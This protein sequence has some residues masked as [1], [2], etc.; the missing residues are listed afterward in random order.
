MSREIAIALDQ[1]FRPQPGGVATYAR[2]LVRGLE[3][4][5]DET[6][7]LVGVTPA[8]R[9]R[10]SIDVLGLSTVSAPLPVEVLTRAWAHVALGVPRSSD[11]VHATS[12]A[13]PF[14]GGRP[15]ARHSL[16][17]HDLLWRDE[18]T[19]STRRG[20]RFHESR[21]DLLR[22]REDVRVITT[23]PGL[24]SRLLADGFSADRLFVSRF[25]VDDDDVAPAPT[26][27]VRALLA[28]HGVAGGFTLYAGT[29]EPRKNLDRLVTAHE[30]AT[31]R[32]REL[33]PLVLVGPEG[34]G[35]VE[36][37]S[38]VVLGEVSRSLLKGLFRDATVVAYVPRAE[39]FGLPPV[40]ALHQG[41]RVVAAP[42]PRAWR[43]TA[44]SSLSR[45]STPTRSSPD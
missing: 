15:T 37:G 1:F 43:T 44:R 35:S 30:S 40:E 42:R 24:R 31:R 6:L 13:G 16:A 20:V 29:R 38:A 45:R 27:E 18:P 36:V 17:V 14:S 5:R 10:Q 19:S 39:G 22:R 12:L 2:G 41:A 21:L 9:A 32:A 4:L 33:G 28:A 3:G 26:D 23:A 34:W 7:Q 8:G 11:V 25:G